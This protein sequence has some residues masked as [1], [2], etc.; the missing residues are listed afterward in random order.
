MIVRRSGEAGPCSN[1][2]SSA[3][4]SGALRLGLVVADVAVG[5]VEQGA[6]PAHRKR[7]VA[8]ARVSVGAT[9]QRSLLSRKDPVGEPVAQPVERI[10]RTAYGV[11]APQRQQVS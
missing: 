11:R 8:Q 5:Q 1:R 2:S 4:A 6:Q 7:R 3:L 10:A 9:G